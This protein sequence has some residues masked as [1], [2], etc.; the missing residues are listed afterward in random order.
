MRRSLIP[1]VGSI[2]LL[3]PVSLL[4]GAD[5]AVTPGSTPSAWPEAR[6]VGSAPR[7]TQAPQ[8]KGLVLQPGSRLRV[9]GS[10]ARQ[11]FELWAGSLLG[12]AILHAPLKAGVPDALLEVVKKQ[13]VLA[14]TLQ[15]PIVRLQA[16]DTQVEDG[17]DY[18]LAGPVQTLHGRENPDVE[19]RL[20]HVK[21]GQE[22]RPGVHSLEADGELTIAGVSR[23][24]SLKAEAA[25]SGDQVRVSGRYKVHLAAF[26]VKILEDVWGSMGPDPS[27]E[28]DYDVAF[29]PPPAP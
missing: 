28:V 16:S 1:F 24:V 13:G 5:P 14:M 2:L 23:Q 19:F 22:I 25:F 12:A 6:E 26:K 9:K 4:L 29:A 15:V 10:T 3:F 27:V 17:S 7:M 21:L 8:G 18:A 20:A 11:P